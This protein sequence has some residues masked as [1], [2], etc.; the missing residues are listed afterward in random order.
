MSQDKLGMKPQYL[1]G[2][3]AAMLGRDTETCPYDSDS[4]DE[5]YDWWMQ[6][7]FDGKH[8]DDASEYKL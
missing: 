8:F 6:G 4:A 7:Y 5:D 3:V 1:H 2:F